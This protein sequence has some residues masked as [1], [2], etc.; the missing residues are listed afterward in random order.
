MG[1]KVLLTA[2]DPFG[3]ESVNPAAEAIQRVPVSIA[4]IEVVTLEVPTVFRESVE[5]VMRAIQRVHPDVV[6]CIGQ[7]GGRNDI[8]VERV[9]INLDDASIVDNAGNQPKD[10]MIAP[11]GPAAIFATIPVKKLVQA[12]R[13]RG[14]PA[15]VSNSAGTFVCNHLFYGVL[16]RCGKEFPGIRV[17]FIHV[18]FL[19]SQVIARP[20]APS[21]SLEV[22]EQA[23]EV[24]IGALD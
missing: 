13:D 8:A 4:G 2:F 24:A 6:L 21:M 9:A 11:D 3:G 19:P 12:I 20:A 18:P 10:T 15:S 23:I 7:A 5:V 14:I 17:G 16:H 1:M 22:I